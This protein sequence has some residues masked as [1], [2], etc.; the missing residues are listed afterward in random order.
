MKY[1][2]TRFV[3]DRK[4]TS[5][6]E[7]SAIIQ[8]EI[9]YERKKKYISTGVK[10]YKDE[11]SDKA[12]VINR[13]DSDIMNN[14]IDTFK[15]QIDEYINELVKNRRAFDWDAFSRFLS[16]RNNS[17]MSFINYVDKRIE[18]R[19]D[20]RESTK[21]SHRKLVNSLDEFGRIIDF[22]DLT[23]ANIADYYDWLLGRDIPKFDKDGN[24]CTVKMS[25]ASAWS[26]MKVLRT[27]IHD[28]MRH[29]LIER[30]P[31][32]GIKVKRRETGDIRWLTNKE[33]DMI[34]KAK[35]PSGSLS[36]VRDL[37]IF[38]CYSGLAYADTMDFKQDKIEE[39]DDMRFIRGRRIKTGEEYIVLML[40]QVEKI[41]EKYEYKLPHYTNQQ[42]NKRLKEL[43][44]AAGIDKPISCHWARHTAAMMF[45]NNGIR[46]ETV[47]RI[48]GHGSTRITQAIYA[49]IMKKTVGN[50]MKG[51]IEEKGR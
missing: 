4:K 23:R 49:S 47:A 33:V 42:L 44:K 11:W 45:L 48:L 18:E 36:R 40:P 13:N 41:L 1:P 39:E 51:L 2:T 26:Y 20:I 31:S 8:V 27:Y 17:S 19:N 5:T 14:R 25:Q 50:E 22:D 30:D 28:A 34:E 37:F 3:F 10:V 38:M 21:R 12:H 16:Y 15:K 6:K 24:E 43:A 32:I 46:L 35:M 9:L 7:K 29:D